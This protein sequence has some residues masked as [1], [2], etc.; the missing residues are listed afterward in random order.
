MNLNTKPPMARNHPSFA[1]VGISFVNFLLAVTVFL[2]PAIRHL[3]LSNISELFLVFSPCAIVGITALVY[4]EFITEY[5]SEVAGLSLAGLLAA[6]WACSRLSDAEP[7]DWEA[8]LKWMYML[9]LSYVLW[10]FIMAGWLLPSKRDDGS[11][12]AA[13]HISEISVLTTHINQPTLATIFLMWVVS[14]RLP[15]HEASKYVSGVVAFHLVFATIACGR[16]LLYWRAVRQAKDAHT[17]Q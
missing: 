12:S 10:D 15:A 1:H 13:R 8:H 6:I 5:Q 14:R 4:Y 3:D 16:T 11:P 2:S 17:S 9:F 7:G